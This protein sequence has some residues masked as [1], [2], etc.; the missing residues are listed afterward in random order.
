LSKLPQV[1]G[2]KVIRVLEKRGFFVH[3][4][5]GSHVALRHKIDRR[6][7]VIVP[8]HK[9]KAIKKGTLRDIIK[10]AGLTVEEFNKLL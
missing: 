6:R 1:T 7:R 8:V 5:K 3:H 10:D 4:Q 2:E 9:G